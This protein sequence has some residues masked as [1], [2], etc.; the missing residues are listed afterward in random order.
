VFNFT[1]NQRSRHAGGARGCRVRLGLTEKSGVSRVWAAPD[2]DAKRKPRT[3]VRR[4]IL[5]VPGDRVTDCLDRQ[6][7]RGTA[8]RRH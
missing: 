7:M 5:A 4:P 2:V 1:F 8:L 3:L 6:Q